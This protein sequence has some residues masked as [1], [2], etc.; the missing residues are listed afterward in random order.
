EPLLEVETDKA[1]LTVESAYSGTVLKILYPADE[2]LE[3]G[4]VIAYVGQPGESVGATPQA[5]HAASNGAT[6]PVAAPGGGPVL[7]SPGAG[8]MPR[9]HG[10]DLADVRGSGPGGRIERK[11]IEALIGGVAPAATSA[12]PAT[13]MALAA[14]A[15]ASDRDVPRHRQV[16]A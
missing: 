1:V 14:Q 6:A 16:I 7:A 10:I 5:A 9:E 4:T 11:D 8:Q 12:A 3:V 15:E 2:T 13:S